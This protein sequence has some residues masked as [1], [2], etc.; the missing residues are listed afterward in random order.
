M[1]N[2]S[3]IPASRVPVLDDGGF[4]TRE[5]YRF[6][7]GL[8]SLTGSGV[9]D[10]SLLDLQ[11]APQSEDGF[12]TPD[13]SLCLTPAS[14]DT[15]RET[16][17]QLDSRSLNEEFYSFSS[18]TSASITTLTNTV[19]G[20]TNYNVRNYLINGAFDFWQR[21]TTTTYTGASSSVYLAD[22]WL[23]SFASAGTGSYTLQRYD[24]KNDPSSGYSRYAITVS[25]TSATATSFEQ[26]IEDALTLQGKYVMASIY[27]AGDCTFNIQLIQNFGTGGSPSSQVVLTSSTLTS[28]SS[29][30]A[31]YA[32]LFQLGTVL[33]KTFG[34][35][36]DSYLSFRVNI[37]S[38]F[39]NLYWLSDCQLEHST[40]GTT[41]AS[42][43]SRRLLGEELALCQRYY[44]EVSVTPTTLSTYAY[45]S[46]P[47]TMR[48]VPTITVKSGSVNGATYAGAPYGTSSIRQQTASA[49]ASDA[50]LALDAEL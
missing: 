15:L 16:N 48:V 39:T 20:L 46:L 44:S 49:G 10:I 26:R 35:N 33:S 1:A 41:T 2:T 18:K 38:N 31:R 42:T 5:W 29:A 23:F 21:A 7:S 28:P 22:R 8:S 9:N 47:T 50:L 3:I 45:T 12:S 43:F 32:V 34:T 40:V 19:N 24:A 13:Q 37:L 4:V 36:N 25:I 27:F 17:L 14:V 6:F 11:L 30:W